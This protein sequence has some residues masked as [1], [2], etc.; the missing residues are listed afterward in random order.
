MTTTAEPATRIPLRVAVLALGTFAVGTDAF[1]VAGVLPEIAADLDVGIAQAGQLVTVFAIAYAVL[2]P[3][4]ATLTGTWP[5]RAVLLTA[6]AVFA[7]G[8]V[9][10][11]LAPSYATVLATRVLA[12]AGAS[13]FTPIA[14]AAAASLAPETQRARAISLVVLGLTV[15]TALGVPLGTLLGSVTSWRGTMWLVAALGATAAIGVAALLPTIPA[16]PA[17]SLRE[18][19]APL[20]DGKITMVLLTTVAFFIGIYT[21]NTYISVIVEPATG[22]NSALLAMLLFLSGAAGTAGNLISGGWTDRF[23]AR[24]VIAVAMAIA[25]INCLLLPITAETLVSA[26]PAVLVFGLTAWSVTVPQQHRLIEAAPSA[27]SLVISLNASGGYLGSSLAGLIGAA[28]LEFSPVSLP[29]V[30]AVFIVI[31]LAAS[32]LAQRIGARS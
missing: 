14:G 15:S 16:P 18:R 4:L 26:V 22:N 28:A 27:T 2:S 1:A 32:E 17:A 10:T 8:N 29:L 21:V 23:G 30:A 31:G 24:R 11:A 3:V 25:F 19:L 7:L 20:R 9:A 12:A 6:L 13:M 5:R